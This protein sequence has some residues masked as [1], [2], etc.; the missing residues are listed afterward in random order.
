MISSQS[1][2]CSL[3]APSPRADNM[4][5]PAQKH[6]AFCANGSEEVHEAD[7][8]DRS[9]VPVALPLTYGCAF[10]SVFR[11]SLTSQWICQGHARA[12]GTPTRSIPCTTSF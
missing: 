7:D 12:Q 1:V 11:D 8:W 5:F 10:L 3:I 4:A 2:R 9:P 6:V